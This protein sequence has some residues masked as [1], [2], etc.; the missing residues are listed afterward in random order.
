LLHRDKV[1]RVIPKTDDEVR[2]LADL[3]HDPTVSFW[4]EAHAPGMAADIH[5]PARYY[6]D[7]ARHLDKN[8]LKFAIQIID[9]QSEVDNE[10]LTLGR[11][12]G[13]FS[14]YK[15]LD[16]IEDE[17]RRLAGVQTL[18]Q[19]T[20]NTVG[21]TYEGPNLVFQIKGR[22][23]PEKPVFF[24][25]CGIH[26][27]EWITPATCMYI[28]TQFITKYRSDK[29]VTEVLDKMD[30]IIM[31]VLNADGYVYTWTGNRMWRKTR[32]PNIQ[33]WWGQKTCYGTDPNRNWGY[34]WG[35]PGASSNPCSDTFRGKTA[36][37]EVEVDNVAK[38]LKGLGPRVKGY[39]DIHA[40]S[41]FW[42]IPW[43]Y[44]T[45]NAKDHKELMRVSKI[46][47]DAI[48]QTYGTAYRYGSSSNI[49]YK[50]SGSSKDYTYGHLNIKYSFALELRDT[51]R[52]G[53]LLPP[54]QILPTAL[55]TFN[56][57][58]AMAKAMEI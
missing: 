25:N 44:T 53:F 2:I 3:E 37:S 22:S 56:G 32:K 26:A 47:V 51:G 29:S 12:E 10:K 23:L 4:K 24:M 45:A 21:S 48:R 39:M 27:R 52:Y 54:G 9:L 55:E 5:V 18:A 43:G 1:I 40:Y 33:S 17:M 35:L 49:I 50:N 14:G 6:G 13:F 46:G 38:F 34:K 7:V 31:P 41:Q 30:F 20:M 58:I 42:M 11:S 28:I 19:V 16:K 36:Q 57:I 8:G 15:P